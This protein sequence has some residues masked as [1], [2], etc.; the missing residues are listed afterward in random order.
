MKKTLWITILAVA[1][2]LM[3]G[4][5]RVTTETINTNPKADRIVS[6]TPAQGESV[7]W[8]EAGVPKTAAIDPE[9]V[10]EFGA[11]TLGMQT[12]AVKDE[13]RS[14][15]KVTLW[16][17]D[18]NGSLSAV[19]TAKAANAK[20]VYSPVLRDA[21]GQ[22]RALP[23]GVI[24]RLNPELSNEAAAQWLADKN[25]TVVKMLEIGKNTFVVGSEAGLASLELANS[26]QNADGVVWAQ[27]EWWQERVK[28]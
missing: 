19:K 5:P 15:G 21:N 20:G 25:L 4:S 13:K 28:K 11:Q 2:V 6:E 24:V 7:T 9:L 27:P 3:A 14:G 10:A 1:P 8:H 17:V 23:G 22:T 12:K 18:K 26:L 16:R